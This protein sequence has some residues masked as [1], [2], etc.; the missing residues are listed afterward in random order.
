LLET[1][2]PA[3]LARFQLQWLSHP[4]QASLRRAFV[5]WLNRVGIRKHLPEVDLGEVHELQRHG[6]HSCPQSVGTIMLY[7]FR[8]FW[9]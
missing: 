2:L 6:M 7:L 3:S 4:E 5:V 9:F 8:Y 1:D